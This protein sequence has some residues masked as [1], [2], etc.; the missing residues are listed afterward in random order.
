[1][2]TKHRTVKTVRCL[3]FGAFVRIQ[4]P[5]EKQR[6]VGNFQTASQL[7]LLLQNSLKLVPQH[8][9]IHPT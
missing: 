8:F 7:F 9:F 6:A 3:F 5:S 2:K 4:R 1:M